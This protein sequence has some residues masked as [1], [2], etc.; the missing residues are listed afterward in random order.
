MARLGDG[1]GRA[2]AAPPAGASDPALVQALSR[3]DNLDRAQAQ[4]LARLDTLDHTQQQK[5]AERLGKIDEV[6][7]QTP[8]PGGT[9]DQAMS[10]IAARLESLDR[11][12][13]KTAGRLDGLDRGQTLVLSRLDGLDRDRGQFSARLDGLAKG[14]GAPG[15]DARIESLSKEL[16][17]VSANLAGRREAASGGAAEASSPEQ[18]L[19]A[20]TARNAIFFGEDTDFRDAAMARKQLAELKDLLAATT[21]RLRLI[22][23]TDLLGDDGNNNR[24]ALERAKMAAQELGKLGIPASRLILAGRAKERLIAAGQ[25]PASANRRVEFQI[26]FVS[27]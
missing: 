18:A 12:Q 19:A 16:A 2:Q 25:G 17:A 15:P 20:W 22:G 27:E 24:L 6:R 23:Y 7:V 3:M 1:A 11:A 26:A 14:A 8:L 10:K 4:I 9:A 13:V 5:T 21:V